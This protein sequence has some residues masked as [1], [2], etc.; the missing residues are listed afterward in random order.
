MLPE[1]GIVE[2]TFFGPDGILDGMGREA[3]YID[4]STI[5]PKLAQ[6]IGEQISGQHGTQTAGGN[7]LSPAGNLSAICSREARRP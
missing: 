7:A 4:M 5:S 3:I 1:N 6:R 2:H